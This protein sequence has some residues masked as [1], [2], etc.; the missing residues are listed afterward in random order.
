MKL[1]IV[2]NPSGTEGFATADKADA[3]YVRSGDARML[4][5]ILPMVGEAF[6][7]AYA[8]NPKEKFQMIQ[9]E[10]DPKHQKA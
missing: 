9:V 5:G 6:R 3:D 2:L 10:V 7:E 4:L 1:Y 8:E